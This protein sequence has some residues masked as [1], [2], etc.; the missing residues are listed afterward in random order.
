M[1]VTPLRGAEIARKYFPHFG[2]NS[3]ARKSPQNMELLLVH[4]QEEHFR[5]KKE[6]KEP[7]ENRLPKTGLIN[8]HQK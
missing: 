3:E 7:E 4:G 6:D 8:V 2:S 1:T 5:K